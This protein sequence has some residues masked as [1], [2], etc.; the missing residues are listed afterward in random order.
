M[1]C[2]CRWAS[3]NKGGMI[4][5]GKVVAPNSINLPCLSVWF[6]KLCFR[7]LVEFTEVL[8]FSLKFLFSLIISRL[9]NHG[10]DPN[11]EIVP[12]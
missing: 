4:V 3:A 9:E 6:S 7:L 5:L 1:L 12:K 11:V 10:L 8:V 2:C